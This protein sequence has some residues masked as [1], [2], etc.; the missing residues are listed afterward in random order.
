MMSFLNVARDATPGSAAITLLTSLFAPGKRSISV[1][2]SVFKETGDS[3]LRINGEAFTITSSCYKTNFSIANSNC[4]TRDL[5]TVISFRNKV[6][7]PETTALK[8]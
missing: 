7:Y 2:L 4:S 5:V 8:E 6:L 1:A 3:F